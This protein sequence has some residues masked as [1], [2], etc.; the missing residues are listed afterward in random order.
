MRP[1]ALIYLSDL[2]S[3]GDTSYAGVVI[4]DDDLYVSYY[5]SDVGRDYAWLLGAVM[6]SDVWMAKVPLSNLEQ[7]ATAK[8]GS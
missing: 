4:K 5:S 6:P 1:D 3:A 2:P 7:L 8:A